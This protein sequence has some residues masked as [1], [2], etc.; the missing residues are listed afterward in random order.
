MP[1]LFLELQ[2]SGQQP[3]PGE[4]ERELGPTQLPGK[5]T[6]LMTMPGARSWLTAPSARAGAPT[7]A[8][9]SSGKV[10]VQSSALDSC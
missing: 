6:E 2:L 1:L 7:A 4:L 10:G 3:C 8:R 9:G 5:W